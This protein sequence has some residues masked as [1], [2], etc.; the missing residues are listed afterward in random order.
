MQ[1]I[2][3]K[4]PWKWYAGFVL[5]G[6]SLMVVMVL[7]PVW[8][9]FPVQ[10]TEGVTVVAVTESGCIADAPTVGLPIN[11][12]HCSAQPGDTVMATY[13]APAKATSGYYERAKEIMARS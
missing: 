5:L 8:H 9:W 11:I 6:V 13:Y 7:N 3:K 12:G 10:V 2:E 4:M 1:Q